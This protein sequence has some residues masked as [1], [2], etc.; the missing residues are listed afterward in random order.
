MAKEN[1]QVQNPDN[2]YIGSLEQILNTTVAQIGEDTTFW[3]RTGRF[4]KAEG[5]ACVSDMAVITAASFFTQ[6]PAILMCVGPG[7]EK[8]VMAASITRDN[9]RDYKKNIANGMKRSEAFRRFKRDTPRDI[10]AATGMDLATHDPIHIGGTYILLERFQMYPALASLIAFSSGLVV[11]GALSAGMTKAWDAYSEWK[12]KQRD[13]NQV[14]EKGF[15]KK[16]KK[17]QLE[18]RAYF[19]T[20]SDLDLFIKAI[21]SVSSM[22]GFQMT[23]FDV[24]EEKQTDSYYD[25]DEMFFYD[26]DSGLKIRHLEISERTKDLEE[27]TKLY[28][29][30][31]IRGMSKGG[32]RIRQR[33]EDVV[34]GHQEAKDSFG[35]AEL[36]HHFSEDFQKTT[37]E[38]ELI[39]MFEVNN[40]K[41]IYSFQKVDHRGRKVRFD[42]VADKFHYHSA[43]RSQRSETFYSVE[44][45]PKR[46]KRKDI[47]FIDPLW[48]ILED[49]GFDGS[50]RYFRSNEPKYNIGV[51]MFDL[52]EC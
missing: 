47:V 29:D 5:V 1:E 39:K 31:G 22:K 32:Y 7:S 9:R 24:R 34:E 6:N 16:E 25:T 8:M 23:G 13:Y 14:I 2:G 19:K 46:G 50:Q 4:L 40:Y 44:I 20:R 15:T 42:V 37:G 28:Y 12:G 36:A 10:A 17:F 38:S 27:V 21:L 33:E 30:S 41:K 18:Q 48:A 52:A 43:D 49:E 35:S 26:N 45:K 3:Q 51:R 11:S